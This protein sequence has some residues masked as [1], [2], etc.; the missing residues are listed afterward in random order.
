MESTMTAVEVTG[1]IDENHQLKLDQPLPITGPISVRVIV[2]YLT[3]EEPGKAQ[4]LQAAA[5][6]PAFEFLNDPEEDIY[7]LAD[8]KPVQDEV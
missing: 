3:P 4:W 7:T 5:N 6:N 1:T 8:G 2:L